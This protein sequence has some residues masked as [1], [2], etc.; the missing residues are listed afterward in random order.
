MT[1]PKT[2]IQAVRYFSDPDV[3][4]EMLAAQR[5]PNGPVCPRCGGDDPWFKQAKG[6]PQNNLNN[7]QRVGLLL[8]GRIV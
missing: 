4:R 2:L 7:C 8:R 1:E 3:C 6:L 5:W